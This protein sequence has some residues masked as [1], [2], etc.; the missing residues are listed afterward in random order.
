MKKIILMAFI[1]VCY[2]LNLNF[3]IQDKIIP[4]KSAAAI[5]KCIREEEP[6]E[7]MVTYPMFNNEN[8]DMGLNRLI[9]KN[10]QNFVQQSK[11]KVRYNIILHLD[12]K[13]E[14]VND[15]FISIFYF[16]YKGAVHNEGRLHS[17]VNTINI[18]VEH[19]KEINKDDF[20]INKNAVLNLLMQD[21]FESISIIESVKGGY[22]FS[23]LAD[24]SS[25]DLTEGLD[26][27]CLSFYINGDNLIFVVN[28]SSVYYEFS[29]A[30]DEIENYLNKDVLE[31]IQH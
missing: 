24:Y 25:I 14:C 9:E 2:F 16:G 10:I 31:I 23:S 30:I 22:K 7:V 29:I 6:N 28:D 15:K 8:Q 20:F 19:L 21:K 27:S 12:Y 13:L 18:D 1:S 4:V 3:S 5:D 26:S 11:D 17:E